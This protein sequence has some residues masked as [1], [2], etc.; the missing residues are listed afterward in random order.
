MHLEPLILLLLTFGVRHAENIIEVH[1]LLNNSFYFVV[2]H[3]FPVR[4]LLF[5]LKEN[6]LGNFCSKQGALFFKLLLKLLR[7][8]ALVTFLCEDKV[9]Q[10][11]LLDQVLYLFPCMLL[12]RNID[13]GQHSVSF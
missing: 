2:L 9:R 1:V 8:F 6:F 5:E 13:V 10:Q 11:V 4:L 7:L 12:V 3:L